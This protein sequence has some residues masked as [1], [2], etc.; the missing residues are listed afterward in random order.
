M[1]SKGCGTHETPA[2]EKKN[3]ETTAL[4]ADVDH[5]VPDEIVCKNDSQRQRHGSHRNLIL[6][7]DA[8]LPVFVVHR[9]LPVWKWTLGL[10]GLL[11]LGGSRIQFTGS[12]LLRFHISVSG[13][14][15]CGRCLWFHEVNV[16]CVV[17]ST[18]NT[19]IPPVCVLTV[20]RSV[21]IV[22]ESR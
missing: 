2:N 10:T 1:A 11:V 7:T 14:G 12:L 22:S 20:E 5:I 21:V 3:N 8:A 13:A 4:A 16:Y 9:V 17:T 19:I 6:V 15:C 18:S